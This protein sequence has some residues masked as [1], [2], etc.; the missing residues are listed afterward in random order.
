[1]TVSIMLG[2]CEYPS[3]T[4]LIDLYEISF[5]S[6]KL[7]NNGIN[8]TFNI[9]GDRSDFFLRLYRCNRRSRAEIDGEIAALVAFMPVHEVYVAK[10]LKLKAGGYVF[11]C[12]YNEETRFACLFT[13]ARGRQ[14]EST[15][16]DMRQL[17]AA[18]A[19]VH[20]Q[21]SPTLACGR[22]FLPGE[23]IDET[24]RHLTWRGTQFRHLCRKI[25]HIGMTFDANLTR[26]A[27]LRRG[28]CH[29]DAWSGN[30]HLSGPRTT[31]FDFDDCFDGPL[32]ADL[33]PQIAWL[34]HAAR[35]EFPLLVKVLLDAYTSLSPLR[36]ADI[37]AIPSLVQLHE[38]G[39]IAFL[40][41][42]C[43]LEPSMWAECL[44]RSARMLDDWSPGGAASAYFA[45]LTGAAR[46]AR[47][48]VA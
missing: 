16:G 7:V 32:V 8:V 40:A 19:V 4:A 5:R 45:P 27:G 1:M 20:R 29:G 26:H 44:E 30:V 18:L 36:D 34:W 47:T 25:R 11:S 24:A 6:L 2:V 21:L 42:Y 37:A 23:V 31:F 28:F 39:S 22:P 46:M 10:P 15:T 9:S 12:S 17:G 33:A 13:A 48:Q 14:A 38:I 43:S 41:K 3:P 35:P